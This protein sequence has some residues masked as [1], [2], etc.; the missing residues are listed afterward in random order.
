MPQRINPEPEERS[1]TCALTQQ[2]QQKVR[3]LLHFHG[4]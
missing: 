3:S 4:N 1:V 2:Q